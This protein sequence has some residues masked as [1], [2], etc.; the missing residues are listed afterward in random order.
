MIDPVPL[1]P[2]TMFRGKQLLECWL[3]RYECETRDMLRIH[4]REKLEKVYYW[5][6]RYVSGMTW[7]QWMVVDKIAPEGQQRRLFYWCME[8]IYQGDLLSQFRFERVGKELRIVVVEPTKEQQE[9]P[10]SVLYGNRRYLLID[11]YDRIKNHSEMYPDIDPELFGFENESAD[12]HESEA[13]SAD[14]DA[15]EYEG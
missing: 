2:C 5:V 6:F 14:E 3:K 1:E 10:M 7:G 15:D 13:R 9:S 8:L 11:W 12:A 4:G